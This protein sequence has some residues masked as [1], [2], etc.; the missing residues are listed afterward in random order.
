MKTPWIGEKGYF[1]PIVWWVLDLGCW[2]S[3]G[4]VFLATDHFKPPI[5]PRS[6]LTPAVSLKKPHHIITLR[7]SE[8]GKD[9]AYVC[10]YFTLSLID[11]I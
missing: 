4:R 10:R 11:T 3:S 1:E 2:P 8:V 5:M 6:G 7:F 9:H